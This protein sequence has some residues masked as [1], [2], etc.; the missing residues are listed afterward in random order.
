MKHTLISC[1]K[2]ALKPRFIPLESLMDGVVGHA[3]DGDNGVVAVTGVDIERYVAAS[4]SRSIKS[5]TM[6]FIPVLVAAAIGFRI[7]NRAIHSCQ[8]V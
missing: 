3:L 8:L 2:V 1:S 5:G 6:G 7:N 4:T